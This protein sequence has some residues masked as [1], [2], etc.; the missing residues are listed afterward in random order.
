LIEYK[1]GDCLGL[2]KEL[3]DESVDLI[4]TDPPYGISKEGI[5]NDDNLEVYHNSLPELYRVLKSCSFFVTFVSI[6]NL[7][8]FLKQ[9]FFVY[10][11]QMIQYIN[12]GMVRGGIGFNRYL[13]ILIFQKG[14]AKIT[15]P[16]LD[17]KEYSTSAAAC[18]KRLHP[19]EKMADFVSYLMVHFSKP[20]AFVLDPFCGSGT[21]LLAARRT[22]RNCLGFEINPEYEKAIKKRIMESTPNLESY[23]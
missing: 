23:A 21:T 3:P 20:G 17:I 16:A 11:W 5:E 15:K 18:E 2:M 7:P 1:I 22:G 8:D 4:L 19:T 9:N 14:E 10:R 12:N 13:S 6:G